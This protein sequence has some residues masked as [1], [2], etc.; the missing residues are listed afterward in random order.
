MEKENI[1]KSIKGIKRA[2]PNPFLFTRIESKLNN[3]AKRTPSIDWF[4][5][6]AFCLGVVFIIMNVMII[7]TPSD[8]QIE[9]QVDLV[10][11]ELPSDTVLYTSII[12]NFN[13]YED[14]SD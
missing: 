1:I 10:E 2:E 4:F 3:E 14:G 8:E 5:R 7:A 13:F 12:Q 9:E 11:I 6:V